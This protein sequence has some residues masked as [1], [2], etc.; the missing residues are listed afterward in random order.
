MDPRDQERP[1][2]AGSL[3]RHLGG[4]LDPLTSAILVFPL[5]LVYQLGILNGR[6]QNGVDFVTK[7]L[8]DIARR[9]A[10]NYLV[11][12]AG[13]LLAYAAV[14]VLLRHRGRFDPRAFLPML[15]ESTL[16]ALV[17]GSLILFVMRRFADFVPGLA[18]GAHGTMDVVVI[19][20]GAGLHEELVFRV[21]LMGGGAW[22][23]SGIMSPGRAWTCALILSA[24]LF[25]LAHH[26]GP[27]GEAFTFAAFTYRVLAGVFFGLVYQVRGFAVAVWTHALYDVYVLSSGAG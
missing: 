10:T 7:A 3:R 9:D 8:V 22:L 14:V 4:R 6:G 13:M 25:S 27:S 19:S 12:L 18:V 5:L 15:L 11:I 17:M 20:A 23:L 2:P 1:A 26:V 24:L 16:Y 21:F